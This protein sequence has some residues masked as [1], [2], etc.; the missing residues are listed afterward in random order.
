MA[1]QQP[2]R[3]NSRINF[4][5]SQTRGQSSPR[6]PTR[7]QKS[8]FSSTNSLKPR[9]ENPR[10]GLPPLNM[11]AKSPLSPLSPTQS[12]P[13]LNK[14]NTSLGRA[15]KDD[16][17]SSQSLGESMVPSSPSLPVP[18]T[19]PVSATIISP[20]S[21][22]VSQSNSLTSPPRYN[23]PTHSNPFMKKASSLTNIRASPPARSQLHSSTEKLLD[24]AADKLVNSCNQYL[25]QNRAIDIKIER[26]SSLPNGEKDKQEK[27]VRYIP[28]VLEDGYYSKKRSQSRSFEPSKGSKFTFERTDKP[29]DR[30]SLSYGTLPH[31]LRKQQRHVRSLIVPKMRKMFEKSKSAEPEGNIS[32][33]GRTVKLKIKIDPPQS[34]SFQTRNKDD[35]LRH[36]DGTE[37]VSSFVAVNKNLLEVADNKRNKLPGERQ[38]SA[39]FSSNGDEW[40]LSEGYDQTPEEN[41]GDSNNF[42]SNRGENA[43]PNLNNDVTS[44]DDDVS[45]STF[46]KNKSKVPINNEGIN[47]GCSNSSGTSS[48]DNNGNVLNNKS[49]VNKC[50]SKVKNLVNSKQSSPQPGQ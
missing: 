30:G 44:S 19:S 38:R 49:F 40:S 2:L 37:S 22:T 36:K 16:I 48:N 13:P 50:V 20:S 28:V 6:P 10:A 5:P 25:D 27:G 39:S 46:V 29:F 31:V 21:S 7:N 15:S 17:E 42:C 12:P 8:N 4:A 9:P 34:P 1:K 14:A 32:L 24:A 43:L 35:H 33:P 41:S 11:A 3:K 18:P 23:A 26:V 45:N 47:K